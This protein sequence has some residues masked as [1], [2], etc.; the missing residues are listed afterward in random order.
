VLSSYRRL[1]LEFRGLT[2][3]DAASAG[4]MTFERP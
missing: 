2:G 3:V 4:D 1:F